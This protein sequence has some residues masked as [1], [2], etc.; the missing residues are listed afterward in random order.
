MKLNKGEL[1]ISDYK[2]EGS[3]QVRI[4]FDLELERLWD[5]IQIYQWVDQVLI[6]VVYSNDTFTILKQ[7][8]VFNDP[9]IRVTVKKMNYDNAFGESVI[10]ED[11]TTSN[12][13]IITYTQPGSSDSPFRAGG[14]VQEYG[15]NQAAALSN[16]YLRDK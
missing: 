13:N 8:Y 2:I 12:G 10:T 4:T 3:N 6:P 15:D 5:T 14:Y 7:N 11:L 9:Y 1:N 16:G